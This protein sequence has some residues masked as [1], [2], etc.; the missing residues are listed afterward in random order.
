VGG[1]PMQFVKLRSAKDW[2]ILIIAVVFGAVNTYVLLY[3]ILH[4]EIA[5]S[6]LAALMIIAL[7][8]AYIVFKESA[9]PR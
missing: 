7:L 8:S 3:P 1:R 9:S 5:D 2:L 6:I 4:S